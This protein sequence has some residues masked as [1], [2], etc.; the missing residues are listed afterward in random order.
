MRAAICGA[1]LALF[2]CAAHGQTQPDAAEIL[3]KVAETYKDVTQYDLA[4][5]ETG[6]GVAKQE[7]A[8]HHMRFVFKAPDKYRVEGVPNRSGIAW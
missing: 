3:K 5:D 2:V 4:A 6:T 7:S 8:D 1:V